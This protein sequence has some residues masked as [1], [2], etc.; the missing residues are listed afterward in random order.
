MDAPKHLIGTA[1]LVIRSMRPRQWI[2]NLFVFAPILFSMNIFQPSHL[3]RASAAFLLFCALAGVVYL[4]NDIVD[5]G[6]DRHHP[7]KR[8]RPLASGLLRVNTALFWAAAIALCSLL[9]SWVFSKAFFWTALTYMAI[10]IAY[11]LWLKAVVILDVMLISAGFVLRVMAG[12]FANDIPLSPWILLITFLLSIFLALVK[13]RQEM[14]R[15]QMSEEGGSRSRAILD[16]YN[17]PFLDQLIALSTA[18][19]LISYFM[20]VLDPRVKGKFHTDWLIVTIPFVVFGV[21]RYLF[22]AYVDNRGENP[23]EVVITDLPFLIN[24]L[25]WLAVF[26]W[27]LYA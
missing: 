14:M 5:R 23:E 8:H 12:G 11:S 4:I 3:L 13:R 6:E 24:A 16:K 19:T 17:L 18:T 27:I 21:F 1:G 10:N 9:V 20:Y 25:L 22:L 15:S 7:V 26:V 2:K